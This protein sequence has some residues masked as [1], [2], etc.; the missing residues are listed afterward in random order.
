MTLIINIL[1]MQLDYILC[2]PIKRFLF[3]N[4]SAEL[5]NMQSV[6]AS[7]ELVEYALFPVLPA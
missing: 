5:K 2:H 7:S 1:T 4:L 6:C 3:H